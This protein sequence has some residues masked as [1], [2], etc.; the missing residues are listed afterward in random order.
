MLELTVT[1][2]ASQ[3][4]KELQR[5]G[6]V[7][8]L[9]T[10]EKRRQARHWHLGFEKQPGALEITDLGDRCILKVASNRDGGWASALAQ[11]LAKPRKRH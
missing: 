6:L 4:I 9:D 10:L 11:E 8:K 1:R 5:R 7:I 2:S 3:L